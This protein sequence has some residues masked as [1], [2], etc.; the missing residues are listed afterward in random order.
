MLHHP[1]FKDSIVAIPL[2]LLVSTF[3]QRRTVKGSASTPYSLRFS[4][5]D[6][7]LSSMQQKKLCHVGEEARLRVHPGSF[8]SVLRLDYLDL[9]VQLL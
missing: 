1:R 2:F 9:K 7:F 3:S 6:Q 4:I 5:E 8:V